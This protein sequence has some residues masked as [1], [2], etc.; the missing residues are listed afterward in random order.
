MAIS[1]VSKKLRDLQTE[2][3]KKSFK[4]G[5]DTQES[6]VIDILSDYA[7]NSESVIASGGSISLDDS[8][9]SASQK[10]NVPFCYVAERKSAANAGIANIFNILS[11]TSQMTGK[12]LDLFGFSSSDDGIA[13]D[14]IGGVNEVT[15]A[16]KN[17]IKTKAPEFANLMAQNNLSGKTL[18]EPYKYLYIT[19][20]T[21]K[22]F[23]F[24]LLNNDSSFASVNNTWGEGEKLPGLIQV[25]LEGFYDLLDAVNIGV[26]L[27]ENVKNFVKG[28]GS[29]IGRVR[30]MAKSFQYP[31]NG[32]SV[33]VNFTLYNTTKVDAWKDNYKF[34]YLFI[35]RNL[36]L[37]IDTMSFLPP[38]LYDV[39]IP[40]VKRLPVCSVDNIN[41]SPKGMTRVLSCENFMASGNVSVNVPEAW[42]VSI[43]FRSL[44][45]HSAN[46]VLAGI[47]N[48][49]N[50]SASLSNG[51]IY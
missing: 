25:P 12:V 19:K 44:I 14:V 50:I 7:W 30:E 45:A 1:E 5:R 37:R 11:A 34:L 33:T 28:E 3:I 41:I 13:G 49:L 51:T 26:N 36:P 24:P 27:A 23:V 21:K 10:T 35:L 2:Y 6:E 38:M 15:T 8:L 29:D 42:E 46:L 4:Y 20:A 18:F 48:G 39:I 9:T 43:T 32:D 17:L 31:S 16:I 47:L 40:G 22:K